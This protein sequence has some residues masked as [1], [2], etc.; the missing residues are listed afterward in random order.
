VADFDVWETVN[1]SL[2]RFDFSSYT[3][4]L[5]TLPPGVSFEQTGNVVELEVH[6]LEGV[7]L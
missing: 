6:F 1:D 5:I 2:I 4:A 3:N 7:S